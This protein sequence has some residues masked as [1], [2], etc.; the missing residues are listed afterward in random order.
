MSIVNDVQRCMDW[1][2]DAV[3]PLVELKLPPEDWRDADTGAYEYRTV[4]PSVHGMYWPTGGRCAAP[5]SCSR[6]LAS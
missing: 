6:T 5:P 1:L 4:H 3:C 2:R